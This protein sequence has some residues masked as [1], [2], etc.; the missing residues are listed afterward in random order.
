MGKQFPDTPPFVIASISYIGKLHNMLQCGLSGSVLTLK[1]PFLTMKNAYQT[2]YHIMSIQYC[3][4][5]LQIFSFVA[6]ISL[7]ICIL[8]FHARYHNLIRMILNFTNVRH[9]ALHREP[10]L[11][12]RS[13]CHDYEHDGRIHKVIFHRLLVRERYP[14]EYLI[15]KQILYLSQ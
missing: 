12:W 1:H 2:L 4:H 15:Q 14:L 13:Q 9:R 11:Q 7:I 10:S 6:M 5:M 3:P 8:Y